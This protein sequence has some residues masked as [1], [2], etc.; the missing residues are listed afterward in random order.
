[1]VSPNFFSVTTALRVMIL[2]G[3]LATLFVFVQSCQSPKLG[4]ESYAKESLRKL[5]V[6]P[7]PP[8][9]PKLSF[10]AP[11]GGNL[12]L[13]DFRGQTILLNVWATWCAPCIAEMPTLDALQK[14]LGGESFQVVTVSLDRTAEEASIWFE[15]NGIENLTAYHDGSF[16][17]SAQLEVRGL[18]IS[19]IYDKRGR[20][21]ARVAG[22]ADW[23]SVEAL[24]FINAVKD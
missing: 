18:P 23:A 17:L 2:G 20:E 15:K 6:L 13:A 19:V 5:T 9:Q 22:D 4:L 21:L 8:P 11:D 10:T 16:A 3:L 7:N 1:M 24:T 14:E 12:T